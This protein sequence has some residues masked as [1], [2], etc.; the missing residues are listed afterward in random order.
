M[1]GV[2]L[3]DSSAAVAG[4]G[5]VS[6]RGGNTGRALFLINGIKA[7]D[8]D[9]SAGTL[10]ITPSQVERIEIVKGPASVLYGP[11]AIDGPKNGQC[12]SFKYYINKLFYVN[13]IKY[14]INKYI[15]FKLIKSI[16]N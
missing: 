15:Y 4:A 10:M 1:P 11:E 16:L 7:A 2:T 14:F 5:R 9:N 6:I 13:H 8:K 12:V 3:D